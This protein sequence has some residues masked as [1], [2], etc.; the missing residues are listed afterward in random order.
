M[1]PETAEIAQIEESSRLRL[2][3]RRGWGWIV[4]GVAGIASQGSRVP[5]AD[6]HQSV[7]VA[8]VHDRD[9]QSAQQIKL[10]ITAH[11]RALVE[12]SPTS[13]IAV[14]TSRGGIGAHWVVDGRGRGEAR[15]AES[16]VD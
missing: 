11:I 2:R 7:G 10:K 12:H 8:S 16:A 14:L 9:L 5:E 3:L 1:N 13:V 15:A 6:G 4:F